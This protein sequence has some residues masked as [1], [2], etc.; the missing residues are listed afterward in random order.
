M[1]DEDAWNQYPQHRKWFNKLYLA[2]VLG[3]NCG[4]CGVGPNKTAQYIVRPIYNLSGMGVGAKVSVIH[5]GD[6][7]KVPPGYFWCE[8][9]IGEHLSV[10][11]RN[12]K[13]VWVVDCVYKGF[14]GESINLFHKWHRINKT[15]PRLPNLLT[16]LAKDYTIQILNVE[17][18][19]D[20]VIEVHL[21]GSP[22]PKYHHMI[23]IYVSTSSKR[24]DPYFNSWKFV[25]DYDDADG[26]LDDPRIGFLVTENDDVN[27]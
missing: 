24:Y 11:Y 15:P 23:P 7:S 27:Y 3:Y 4:P 19:G 14:K 10:D 1:T 22:D 13:G 5:K 20:K 21:R 8:R 26:F 25:S 9:F 6:P 12:D 18:I 17:F 2:S 16:E